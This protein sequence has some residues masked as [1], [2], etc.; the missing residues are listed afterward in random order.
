MLSRLAMR[1]A[2]STRALSI[3]SSNQDSRPLSSL[4]ISRVPS[5]ASASSRRRTMG[6]V[7]DEERANAIESER[8]EGRGAAGG[9]SV[10]VVDSSGRAS[11]IV[12]QSVVGV[13]VTSSHPRRIFRASQSSANAWRDFSEAATQISVFSGSLRPGE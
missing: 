2:F 7:G 13:L 3:L 10:P 1:R 12:S 9:S 8:P 5:F 11:R 6:K 4:V